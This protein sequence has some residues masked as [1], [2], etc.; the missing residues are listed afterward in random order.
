MQLSRMSMAW[1][2]IVADLHRKRDVGNAAFGSALNGIGQIATLITDGPL[3]SFLYGWLS[4][5]DLC[6]QQTDVTPYS[7]P[8]LCLSPLPSGMVE[9]RYIDTAIRDRQWHRVV[10]PHAA[11]A[12]F[13]AFLDQLGWMAGSTAMR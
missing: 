13:N 5:H 7:G 2:D 4:M 6:L 1:A 10:P 9:F 12:R 3:S 8:Y 11:V